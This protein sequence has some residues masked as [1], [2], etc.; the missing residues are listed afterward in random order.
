MRLKLCAKAAPASFLLVG[1]LFLFQPAFLYWG[2]QSFLTYNLGNIL[3]W[4]LPGF[5]IALSLLLFLASSIPI[6]WQRSY[7][8]ILTG[9][10]FSMWIAALFSGDLGQLDGKQVVVSSDA[11]S[12]LINAILLFCVIGLSAI[13]AYYHTKLTNYF[14]ILISVMFAFFTVWV[15]IAAHKSTVNSWEKLESELLAFSKDKNILLIVLDTFQSDFFQEILAKKTSLGSKFPGFI[16]FPDAVSAAGGTYL[17]IPTIH[18]GQVYK[19]G[20]PVASFYTEAVLQNS[21]VK[22]HVE[23][24]YR[25]MILNPFLGYC[26][27]GVVCGDDND[28]YFKQQAVGLSEGVLLFKLSCFKSIP[29]FLQTFIYNHRAR[30]L[31]A[32]STPRAVISNNVLIVLASSM[33]TSSSTPTVKFIHLFNTHPPAVFNEAC[34]EVDSQIWDRHTAINQDRCAISQVIKVIDSLKQRNVY[35]QTAIMIVA[36]HGAGLPPPHG[37]I[38]GVS[39][40]PLFLYKPFNATGALQVSNKLVGL[41]DVHATLCAMTR[42]CHRS[43]AYGYDVLGNALNNKRVFNFSLYTWMPELTYST[44]KP[45]DVTDFQIIGAPEK[46]SSWHKISV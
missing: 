7:I 34:K 3:M 1:N 16:Y 11:R 43:S 29:K 14:L 30:I 39:A 33:N 18:S 23:S 9:I 2:N 40:N 21:F 19:S 45:C 10:T 4:L 28:M 13:I 25:G 41:V 38:L 37:S 42:D 32:I 15:I 22:A 44:N 36:D 6:R 46:I 12:I 8:A 35:D 26:P 27:K 31:H 17:S 20:Q 24:G 5:L